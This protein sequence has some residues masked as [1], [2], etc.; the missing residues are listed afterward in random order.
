M[1]EKIINNNI[2]LMHTLSQLYI[3]KYNISIQ[4]FLV[5]DN[6]T[7]VLNFIKECPDVFDSLPKEEMLIEMERYINEKTI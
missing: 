3:K 4:D 2:Y 1:S 5:L 6:K 7:R